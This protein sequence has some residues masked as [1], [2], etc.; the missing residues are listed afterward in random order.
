MVQN[1]KPSPLVSVRKT[2][3]RIGDVMVNMFVS[4]VVDSGFEFRMPGGSSQR[5]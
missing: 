2:V 3:N 4:N 1:F 5:Q